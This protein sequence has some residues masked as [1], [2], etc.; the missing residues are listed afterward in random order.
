MKNNDWDSF[1]ITSENKDNTD[2]PDDIIFV[3]DLVI[4]LTDY[5]DNFCKIRRNDKTKLNEEV[6]LVI[7]AIFSVKSCLIDN[8]LQMMHPDSHND[9][10][11]EIIK[12][13]NDHFD[14]LI[15]KYSLNIGKSNN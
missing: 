13:N 14:E 4:E 3:K 15:R 9:F 7:M 8:L 5:I 2:L 11:E 6:N 1:I 10:I 12:Y